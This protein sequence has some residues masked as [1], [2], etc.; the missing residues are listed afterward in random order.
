MAAGII[1]IKA[2][3]LQFLLNHSSLKER[4]NTRT[5]TMERSPQGKIRNEEGFVDGAIDKAFI[6]EKDKNNLPMIPYFYQIY[7]H[8][9]FIK[10]GKLAT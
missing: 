9:L 6:K 2:I 4:F 5:N 8:M 3:Q 1:K 10:S 7:L